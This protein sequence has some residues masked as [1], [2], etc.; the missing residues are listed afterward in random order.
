MLNLPIAMFNHLLILFVLFLAQTVDISIASPKSG[1]TLRGQVDIVGNMNVP[2]FASAE[3][4]FSYASNPADSWFTIQTFPQPVINP[5]LAVWDTTTVTDGDY[6]LHLRVFLQDGSGDLNIYGGD[7]WM[8]NQEMQ[9][10]LKFA[11]YEVEHVW[12]EGGHNG[13]HAAAVFPQALRWLWKGWPAGIGAGS[14]KRDGSAS[15]R[16]LPDAGLADGDGRHERRRWCKALSRSAPRRLRNAE[17]GDG[18]CRNAPM[19][20]GN[21]G[22]L[23]WACWRDPLWLSSRSWTLPSS[24]SG[25]GRRAL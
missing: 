16:C 10:A 8:A 4:A 2:N 1:D 23:T 22:G 11:G 20:P 13:K 3:L 19:E 12:G 25:N 21:G 7:W 24:P 9:R 14:F 6:V 17:A 18:R 5:T 15:Q